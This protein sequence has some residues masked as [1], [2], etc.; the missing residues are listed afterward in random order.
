MSGNPSPKL[1][2][3]NVVVCMDKCSSS[4]KMFGGKAPQ[5]DGSGGSGKRK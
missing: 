5:K 4:V 3:T 2:F 1:S